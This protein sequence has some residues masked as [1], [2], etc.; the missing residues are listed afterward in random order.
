M[1]KKEKKR[2]FDEKVI[3]FTLIGAAVLYGVTLLFETK[4]GQRMLRRAF[5]RVIRA[6]RKRKYSDW[7]VFSDE[8]ITML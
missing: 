1:T 6:W 2:M 5:R 3:I 8:D 7:S 4:T